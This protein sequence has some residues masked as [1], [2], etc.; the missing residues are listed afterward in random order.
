MHQGKFSVLS[1]WETCLGRGE[2]WRGGL[3]V[4]GGD[5]DVS[6]LKNKMYTGVYNFASWLFLQ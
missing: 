1:F 2:G 3:L 6:A 5:S 4:G